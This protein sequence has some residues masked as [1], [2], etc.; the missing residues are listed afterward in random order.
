MSN[1][2]LFEQTSTYSSEE[3][4]ER[5]N[6]LILIDGFN[7]MHHFKDLDHRDPTVP[8]LDESMCPIILLPLI[9][10]WTKDG[11]CVKVVLRN[12]PD[13]DKV[14]HDYILRELEELGFLIYNNE[15][16]VEN[17]DLLMLDLAM[18]YGA[19]IITRDQFRNHKGYENIAELYSVE[20]EK[21]PGKFS[22]ENL[23]TSLSYKSKCEMHESNEFFYAYKSDND[24][25]LVKESLTAFPLCNPY[26]ITRL[27][28]LQ[29]FLYNNIRY[30]YNLG[31]SKHINFL[32][33]FDEFPMKWI[34]FRSRYNGYQLKEDGKEKYRQKPIKALKLDIT[35]EDCYLSDEEESKA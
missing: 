15:D 20:Y 28:I 2:A 34:D 31:L 30:C 33:P 16:R 25:E 10:K 9:I 4:S 29:L 32:Q 5:L 35:E 21:L 7:V 13:A 26:T 23:K 3:S 12:M 22:I 19:I 11:H 8:L 27:H 6:R 14:S 18:K 24:Y 17:D 1:A